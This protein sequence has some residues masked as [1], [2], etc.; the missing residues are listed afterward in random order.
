M[1][2]Y[3]FVSINGL[4]ISED[5][6]FFL[7]FITDIE[8]ADFTYCDRLPRINCV[9]DG[10]T[11]WYRGRKIRISNINTPEISRPKCARE[12]ALGKRAKSRLFELLNDGNFT[13][14]HGPRDKDYY[15]RYLR[16]VERKGTNLGDILI[17]EGL[18]HRW[19]GRR[20]SWC[21]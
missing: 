6:L 15:G 5:M 4:D 1:D 20:E 11:F 3:K 8:R 19:K 13:L 18:A 12:L 7:L 9:V 17:G 16:I 14:M 2:R 10:D 21:G